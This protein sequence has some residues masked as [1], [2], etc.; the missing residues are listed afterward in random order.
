MRKSRLLLVEGFEQRQACQ[1]VDIMHKPETRKE[2]PQLS[3]LSSEHAECCTALI[4]TSTWPAASISTGQLWSA[5]AARRF[6]H[7]DGVV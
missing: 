5:G 6:L 1:T 4:C 3:R 2:V 7:V